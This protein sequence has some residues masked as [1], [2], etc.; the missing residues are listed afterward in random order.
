[1][2]RA[3]DLR[4]ALY[5]AWPE[6]LFAKV[7]Q[8]MLYWALMQ[9]DQR[10]R[11]SWIDGREVLSEVVAKEAPE[12]MSFYT[13]ELLDQI[14][15]LAYVSAHGDHRLPGE[16]LNVSWLFAINPLLDSDSYFLW[17]EALLDTDQTSDMGRSKRNELFWRFNPSAPSVLPTMPPRRGTSTRGATLARKLTEKSLMAQ[18]QANLGRK[19]IFFLADLPAAMQLP[20][21]ASIATVQWVQETLL[22]LGFANASEAILAILEGRHL[23]LNIPPGQLAPRESLNEF[24]HLHLGDLGDLGEMLPNDRDWSALIKNLRDIISKDHSERMLPVHLGNI[25][26]IFASVTGTDA[27]LDHVALL[28]RLIR[29]LES[30][31][32]AP[33]DSYLLDAVLLPIPLPQPLRGRQ[34]MKARKITSPRQL[35]VIA[36]MLDPM[37]APKAIL[38][39]ARSLGEGPAAKYVP[40]EPIDIEPRT[41]AKLAK[42]PRLSAWYTAEDLRDLLTSAQGL[43]LHDLWIANANLDWSTVSKN[44]FSG[45]FGAPAKSPWSIRMLPMFWRH[46]PQASSAVAEILSPC[47]FWESYATSLLD[48][49]NLARAQKTLGSDVLRALLFRRLTEQIF[50]SEIK[51][52]VLHSLWLN[53]RSDGGRKR[54]I[55]DDDLF[56]PALVLP[57]FKRGSF[58]GMQPWGHWLLQVHGQLVAMAA[59]PSHDL[60][61]EGRDSHSFA[62][63][64]ADVLVKALQQQPLEPGEF[65]ART[66]AFARQLAQD[67][68]SPPPDD[69]LDKVL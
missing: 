32:G 7:N 14:Q 33:H 28:M 43:M 8:G 22:D 6:D 51:E 57:F 67:V 24:L 35:A 1:M 26:D 56:D 2:S 46:N 38:K 9:L 31:L 15:K 18:A 52:R 48:Q 54:K 61:A 62:S 59:S 25:F 23:N 55:T 4:T 3:D 19:R 10:T 29:S 68:G 47:S 17:H 11:R 42:S 40:I 41:L 37:Q 50:S 65:F 13:A 5:P 53:Y 49:V 16:R 58:F 20:G 36:S 60:A 64:L 66:L 30:R 39:E 34:P 69:M 27:F 12:L 21:A 44:I 63:D 45:L